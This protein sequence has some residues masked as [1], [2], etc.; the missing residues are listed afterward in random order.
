MSYLL[1]PNVSS[2]ILTG[3]PAIQQISPKPAADVRK[4]QERVQSYVDIP[5]TNMRQT[6]A[7]RLTYS[8]VGYIF[9]IIP[10]FFI[11]KNSL[12]HGLKGILKN[13]IMRLSLL[14]IP[15][16]FHFIANHST[17]LHDNNNPGG[18]HSGYES[19][20]QQSSWSKVVIKRFCGESG[21]CGTSS[22]RFVLY[23]YYQLR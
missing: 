18:W 5:L 1:Q 15:I 10:L 7:K 22:K 19:K 9:L 13:T 4:K 21:R 3:A 8:K 2:P 23:I 17:R 16:H 14:S 11:E 12:I 20:I 6:I